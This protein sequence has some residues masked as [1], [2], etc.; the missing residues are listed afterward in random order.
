MKER[1][2]YLENLLE[3]KERSPQFPSSWVV[4]FFCVETENVSENKPNW[5][6]HVVSFY[7]AET[8]EIGAFSFI[9]VS[10]TTLHF[11]PLQNHLLFPR[12]FASAAIIAGC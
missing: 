11:F 12:V 2:A 10:I 7:K 3:G 5:V 6:K 9:A 1:I 4:K 8:Q